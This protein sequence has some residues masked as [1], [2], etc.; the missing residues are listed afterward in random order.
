MKLLFSILLFLLYSSNIF[1]IDLTSERSFEID[2]FDESYYKTLAKMNKLV[3]LTIIHANKIDFKKIKLNAGI[4]QLSISVKTILN[5]EELKKYNNISSL[6]IS[7]SNLVDISTLHHLK[8]LQFLSLSNNKIHDISPL[9][10]LTKLKNLFINWNQIKDVNVNLPML[11]EF[12]ISSNGLD[13]LCGLKAPNLKVIIAE[14]NNLV[15]INCLAQLTSLEAL[16]LDNNPIKYLD[17]LLELKA[18]TYIKLNWSNVSNVEVFEG[19]KF[20]KHLPNRKNN[21]SFYYYSFLGLVLLSW[22]FVRTKVN[23]DT[24]S[25]LMLIPSF[26]LIILFLIF[27]EQIR[28]VSYKVTMYQTIW[29]QILFTVS[30]SIYSLLMKKRKRSF[31]I[32]IPI[33]IV[34]TI[35]IIWISGILSSI[36]IIG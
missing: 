20:D 24:Y 18:L 29:Y 26:I 8:N 32:I 4:K 28:S 2:L 7:N 14:K 30:I 19:T 16:W 9:N 36:S 3:S 21:F 22:F 23:L 35:F 5:F 25:L 34:A 27:N 1:A 12:S 17:K 31:L 13:S 11:E 10:N 33:F 15:N 6:S